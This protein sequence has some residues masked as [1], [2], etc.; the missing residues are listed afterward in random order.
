MNIHVVVTFRG[1]TRTYKYPHEDGLERA[2]FAARQT[3]AES[4][5]VSV[6]AVQLVTS[7]YC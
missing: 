3:M 5:G 1:E 6:D 2:E 7:Y 4:V